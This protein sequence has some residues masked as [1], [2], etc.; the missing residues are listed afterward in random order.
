MSLPPES[1]VSAARRWV[2]LLRLT[3]PA[4]AHALILTDAAYTDLTL[5]QYGLGFDLLRDLGLVASSGALDSR[6]AGT[7]E[8]QAASE[9][10]REILKAASPP[11]LAAVDGL[12]VGPDDLPS[13]A[14]ALGAALGLSDEDVW[15]CIR[16]TAA[17]VDLARRA[18]IGLAGEV[19]LRDA[20]VVH[21]FAVEHVS[22]ST[23][24]LGYDLSVRCR[25]SEWHLEVKSTTS[26]AQLTI[27]ISRNEYETSATDP[28]WVMVAVA[29]SDSEAIIGLGTVDTNALRAI[30]PSDRTA[31]GR[32]EVA[33]LR[34]PTVSVHSGLEFLAGCEADVEL[35]HP[36]REKHQDRVWWLPDE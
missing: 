17:K 5:T 30:T 3:D 9:L 16:A 7:D 10:A 15:A 35:L 26:R 12:L 29:L 32:W 13:N 21:G 2:D 25:D 31:A 33:K 28:R 8:R 6:L 23:D 20:L 11:W 1:T 27:F 22:L 34:I 19:A 14:R 4:S 18:R 36:H 24:A